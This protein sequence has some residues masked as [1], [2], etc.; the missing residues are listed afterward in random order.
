MAF[1]KKSNDPWNVDPEKRKKEREKE[2]RRAEAQPPEWYRKEEPVQP[3]SCPWCGAPM[4][5]GQLYGSASRGTYS[6]MTWREGAHKSFLESIGNP[7]RERRLNLGYYET[8]WYCEACQK[9]TLDVGLALESA[10]PN[11][12]WK[13]GKIVFPEEETEE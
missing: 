5:M 3:E 13:D 11:Y 2:E 6:G 7:A 8:A 10:R 4:Q 9:M 12:E 1:F